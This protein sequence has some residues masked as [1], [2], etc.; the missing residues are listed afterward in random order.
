MRTL[1]HRWIVLSPIRFFG[2]EDPDDKGKKKPVEKPQEGAKGS[3]EGEEDPPAEDKFSATYVEKLRAEAAKHRVNA[4]EAKTARE[5]VE[6]ELAKLKQ[7]EMSDLEKANTNL[8]TTQTDLEEAES[9]RTAAVADLKT[10]RI[11]N[12]VTLAAVKAK[13]EDPTDALSMISQDDLVDDEGNIDEKLVDKALKALAKSK[14]YLLQKHSAGSGDGAGSG[15]PKD[16]DDY[17]GKVKKH[18]EHLTAGGRIVT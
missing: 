7:A 5:A 15:V 3:G 9:G 12:A 8:E 16:P 11:K 18:L 2:S 13:F 6:A 17:Q 1:Q 10:E 14:P 4:K